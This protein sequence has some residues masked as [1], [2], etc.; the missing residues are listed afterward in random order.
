MVSVFY[1]SL[2]TV[3]VCWLSLNVVKVRRQFRVSVGD[4]DNAALKTAMAAQSNAIEYSPLALLLLFALEYNGAALWLVHLAGAL[5]LAGRL[6]HARGL[7]GGRLPVRVLGMQLTIFPLLA[8][9]LLNLVY[10]PYT[11]FLGA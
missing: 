7:L 5:F 10:L 11:R 3:L 6:I 8:L 1:A 9:A 2:L 4:G